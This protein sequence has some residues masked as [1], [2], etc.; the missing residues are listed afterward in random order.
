[1]RI[2][3]IV[4]V[5]AIIGVVATRALKSSVPVVP[6]QGQAERT[7]PA[8]VPASRESLNQFRD[9]VNRLTQEGAAER[10]RRT[11]EGSR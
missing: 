4:I 11:E 5:V 6:P 9:D 7:A 1:M 2:V 10:A 8:A 3:L